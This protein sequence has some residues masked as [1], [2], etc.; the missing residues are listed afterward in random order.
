[1]SI[2]RYRNTPARLKAWRKYRNDYPDSNKGA[3]PP[4]WFGRVSPAT[5][6]RKPY[7]SDGKTPRTPT[8]NYGD[9]IG[10]DI[11]RSRPFRFVGYSDEVLSLR[12]TGWFGDDEGSGFSVLRGVVFQIPARGGRSQY[13]AGVEWGENGAR[14]KFESGGGW[15]E[16]GRGDIYESK[17]DA[18]RAADSLAENAAEVERE[19]HR[20][21]AERVEREEEEAAEREEAERANVIA[22]HLSRINPALAGTGYQ[23]GAKGSD[24]FLTNED[25]EPL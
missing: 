1:M 23:I 21:E 18:A 17:E 2:Y 13:L 19:Y 5:P 8:Y 3:L 24:I 14:G 20:K 7:E 12:H 11:D 10:G 16:I 4:G 9:G 25:G 22:G 6:N 15:I